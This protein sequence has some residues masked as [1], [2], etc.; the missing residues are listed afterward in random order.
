VAHELQSQSHSL[1]TADMLA[2]DG[3]TYRML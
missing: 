1:V 2:Y 3:L